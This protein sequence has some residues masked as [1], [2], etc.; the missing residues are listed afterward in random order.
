MDNNLFDGLLDK[1]HY[2]LAAMYFPEDNYLYNSYLIRNA[3]KVALTNNQVTID[4]AD[5]VLDTAS[6][7][8]LIEASKTATKKGSVA[9]SILA[10]MYLSSKEKRSSN[11]LNKA[12]KFY[13]EWT[14]R[15]KLY[16]DETPIPRG[17]TTLKAYIRE[18]TKVSQYW[19]TFIMHKHNVFIN[20]NLSPSKDTESFIHAA[21]HIQEFTLEYQVN[22]WNNSDKAKIL[23]PNSPFLIPDHIEAINFDTRQDIQL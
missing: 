22:N 13:G 1:R 14:S 8:E 20:E 15:T 4:L 18:L 10:H 7:N 5:R 2:L 23:N 19:A 11:S 9:G 17:E 6:R 16:G 3:Y 21:K 12:I